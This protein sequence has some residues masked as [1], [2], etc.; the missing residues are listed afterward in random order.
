MSFSFGLTLDC[1][2]DPD[3]Q[4]PMLNGYQTNTHRLI[5][6]V[7][8]GKQNYGAFANPNFQSLG[9]RATTFNPKLLAMAD[10]ATAGSQQMRGTR[11]VGEGER[12]STGCITELGGEG[13]TR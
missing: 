10:G 9:L 13:A 1:G 7:Q 12:G 4:N 6:R 11:K 8:E 5:L 3:W 2:N